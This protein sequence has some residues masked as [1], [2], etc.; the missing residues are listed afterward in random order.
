MRRPGT[1]MSVHF[2]R[3]ER[4]GAEAPASRWML[5][6]VWETGSIKNNFIAIIMNEED[7]SKDVSYKEAIAKSA[8]ASTPSRLSWVPWEK[9][10]TL[11]TQVTS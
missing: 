5:K 9:E 6:I 11:R 7:V 1:M 8:Y 10:H 4:L 2:M 3:H